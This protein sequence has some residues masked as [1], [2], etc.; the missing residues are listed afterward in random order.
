MLDI[1]LGSTVLLIL[2][3]AFILWPVFRK[4]QKV[5]TDDIVPMTQQALNIAVYKDRLEELQ[6]EK[7][8]GLITES[9]F[10]ELLTELESSLLADADDK[11]DYVVTMH[12]AALQKLPIT[13]LM[14][15][16]IALPLAAW[17]LYWKWGAYVSLEDSRTNARVVSATADGMPSTDIEQLLETLQQRL[18]ENPDNLDGWFLLGRSYMNMERFDEAA[19]AFYKVAALLEK[20]EEDPSAVYG[21]VAQ[22]LYFSHQGMSDEVSAV[23]NKALQ[24]NP[25]EINSLGLLGM[26]AFD[27]QRYVDAISAWQK[28]L[29][30]VPAHPSRLAI[31]E[32]INKARAH[33][34]ETGMAVP[35]EVRSSQPS[36]TTVSGPRLTINVDISPELKKSASPEDTLFVYA[37]AMNGPKM[38]LAIVRKQVKDLPFVVVLDD[39]MAMGPMA[40][41]SSF[42]EVEVLARVSKLGA[43]APNPGD[44]EGRL[45]PIETENVAGELFV[46][47]E[48]VVR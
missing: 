26:E 31:E 18:A 34:N 21:M 10:E 36:P 12:K 28:I 48:T 41:L 44:L 19:A 20:Q 25:N 40:K 8:N 1:W 37:R 22:A 32:G 9:K 23:M 3:M 15:M 17:G 43:P 47:I 7:T 33:L 29:D 5:L 46:L 45:G 27:D 38:P 42:P 2:A 6:K 35:D 39:S 13:V 14:V 24:L 16:L 30:V 4:K 11:T